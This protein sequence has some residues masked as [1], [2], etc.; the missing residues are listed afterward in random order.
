MQQNHLVLLLDPIT[1]EKRRIVRHLKHCLYMGR[2]RERNRKHG[3]RQGELYQ[4]TY[5]S[6]ETLS[7]DLGMEMQRSIEFMI[8]RPAFFGHN[9]EQITD[10]T[11]ELKKAS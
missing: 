7:K 4:V 2:V 5:I 10:E 6:R 1:D 8:P 3:G 9:Y 11:N